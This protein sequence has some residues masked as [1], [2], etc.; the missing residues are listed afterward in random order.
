M[1]GKAV[2]NMAARLRDAELWFDQKLTKATGTVRDFV[3]PELSP[4]RQYSYEVK[5]Y[6]ASW[7]SSPG[8]VFQ[9]RTGSPT[10]LTFTAQPTA[11]A[12]SDRLSA[13]AR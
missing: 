4:G 13:G 12:A 9:A 3:T 10:Q 7:I 11:D 5:A 2:S 1:P 6:D 8:T